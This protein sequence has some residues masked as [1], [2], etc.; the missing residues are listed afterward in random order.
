MRTLIAKQLSVIP[1][2]F[3]GI[4]EIQ[5]CQCWYRDVGYEPRHR[6]YLGVMSAAVDDNAHYTN[7]C[8]PRTV[9]NTLAVVP[10]FTL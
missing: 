1:S 4:L 2:H 9:Q 5:M 8:D 6:K 7:Q 3:S 10:I